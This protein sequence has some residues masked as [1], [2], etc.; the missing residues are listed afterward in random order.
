[1]SLDFL[2]NTINYLSDVSDSFS[3]FLSFVH[4]LELVEQ[5]HKNQILPLYLIYLNYSFK[6]ANNI[7]WAC[8]GFSVKLLLI[9]DSF[10][11]VAHRRRTVHV[12]ISFWKKVWII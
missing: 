3:S 7:V 12:D 10:C 6:G 1:M 2:D 9:F 4:A 5:V 11:S 8:L